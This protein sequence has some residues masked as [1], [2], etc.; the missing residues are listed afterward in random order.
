[1]FFNMPSPGTLV[2]ESRTKRLTSGQCPQAGTLAGNRSGTL[3]PPNQPHRRLGHVGEIVAAEG[4]RESVEHNC[5][6]KAFSRRQNARAEFF[7]ENSLTRSRY[8]NHP[9]DPSTRARHAQDDR[10]KQRIKQT[11]PR[12][13]AL[14]RHGV[15]NRAGIAN[16]F[17]H[18]FCLR[19][20]QQIIRAA[21]F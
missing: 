13:F 15:F 16:F 21:G 20:Q 11:L 9:R 3:E 5:R 2:P 8:L 17:R 12:F 1:M 18:G 14:R 4:S 7:R 6:I 19:K 10:T